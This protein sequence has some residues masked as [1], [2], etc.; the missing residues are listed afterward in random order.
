MR[1]L[2]AASSKHH[3][4]PSSLLMHFTG[5]PAMQKE[6]LGLCVQGFNSGAE[7][8]WNFSSAHICIGVG[9]SN[10]ISENMESF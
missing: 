3:T 7:T 2:F 9:G 1:L 10:M 5:C 8:H 6:V 4:A